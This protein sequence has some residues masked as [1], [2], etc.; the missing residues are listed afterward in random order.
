MACAHAR[1]QPVWVEDVASA[2][3]RL[4]DG[5]APLQVDYVASGTV[6]GLQA[7]GIAHTPL[8]PVARR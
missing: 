3:V 4:V 1:F 5:A 6:P 2:V 7:L 8:E